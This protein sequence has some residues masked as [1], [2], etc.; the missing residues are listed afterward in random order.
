M[1]MKIVMI[2]PTPFFADRGCHT[3]IYGEIKGLQKI[4]YRVILVTY[5]LGRDVP[6]VETVR[7]FNFPWYHKLTAGPSVWKILLLPFIAHTARKTI[8][9]EKPD[10]VH[11]HLHEGAL[12]A[13]WCRI[14]CR[15]PLYF[16]DCQGSLSGELAGHH[17]VNAK[18][19]LFRMV[20]FVE[21]KI[22]HLFPIVTQSEQ[23]VQ[24]LKSFGVPD[25]KICNAMDAVDTDLYHP[26][27]PDME[28]ARELKID[29]SRPRVLYMG[30][31]SEYQGTSLMIQA[32]AHAAK[33]I[34]DVQFIIIGYPNEE[35]YKQ[36]V[37]DAGIEKQTVFIGKISYEETARY[38]SLS[39]VAVAPKIS[40]AEGDGK[41][42]NY[43]AMRMGIACF[44]RSVSREI[45]G[46]AGLYAP[47][48]DAQSLGE[49]LICL[50]TD[51]SEREQLGEKALQR[52]KRYSIIESARKI[53]AFYTAVE[54]NRFSGSIEAH[55][56]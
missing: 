13:A 41:L 3:R 52:A 4:G 16:F 14:F 47:L 55:D 20:R 42:Y 54:E 35:R 37:R 38:L 34:P 36:E 7:C 45:L 8:R 18:G 31:L 48:G 22:D 19:M 1:D 24:I 46:D 44:D 50:L 15:K 2:A 43:M 12:T 49:K 17:A 6:G 39:Q 30:L 40:L 11:A 25:A 51:T 21:R 28:L 26:M 32:F 5:G 27:E 23:Q 56:I 10:V 53:D 29:L 33:R 9:R